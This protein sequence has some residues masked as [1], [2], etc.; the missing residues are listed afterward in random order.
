MYHDDMYHG[1]DMYHEGMPAAMEGMD[2]NQM[3]DM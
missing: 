2:C 3:C 1:D